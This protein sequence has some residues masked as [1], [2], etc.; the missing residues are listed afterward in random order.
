MT[1]SEENNF[2]PPKAWLR[3]DISGS[4]TCFA[5]VLPFLSNSRKFDSTA[6]ETTPSG[7]NIFVRKPDPDFL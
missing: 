6:I 7:E 4:L 3:V 2:V 5:Y 1:P